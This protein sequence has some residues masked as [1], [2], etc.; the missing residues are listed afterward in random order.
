MSDDEMELYRRDG[1]DG[2]PPAG[3]GA[4][5]GDGNVWLWTCVWC[6]QRWSE[7][8]APIVACACGGEVVCHQ[9]LLDEYRAIRR[10]D[11]PRRAPELKQTLEEE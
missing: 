5:A 4:E 9:I 8:I 2:L 6:G 7:A 10:F 1:G 3:P 11:D